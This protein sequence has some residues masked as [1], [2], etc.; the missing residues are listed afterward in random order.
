MCAPR[1]LGAHI[2]LGDVG[3]PGAQTAGSRGS[4][5]TSEPGNQLFVCDGPSERGVDVVLH[6]L[7]P[8][9]G[10]VLTGA[11]AT[12]LGAPLLFKGR[13]FSQTDIAQP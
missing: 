10:G 7:E 3:A 2:D 4:A 13:D 11:L 12:C 8:L 6:R 9:V 5:C 1:R